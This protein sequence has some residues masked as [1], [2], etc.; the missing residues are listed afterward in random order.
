MCTLYFLHKLN[1][2]KSLN[3]YGFT[4]FLD[5]YSKDY[6][7]YN[8]KGVMERMDITKN[9]KQDPQLKLF[10]NEITKNKKIIVDKYILDLI[11]INKNVTFI[12]KTCYRPK[13]A[14][15]LFQSIKDML[16]HV[17]LILQFFC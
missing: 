7:N 6:R 12:I 1:N 9:H 5:G 11:D 4:F 14:E 2:Y 8:S 17:I 15:R 16:I 10:K 3:V 13:L